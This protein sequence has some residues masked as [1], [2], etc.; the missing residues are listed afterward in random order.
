[1]TLHVIPATTEDLTAGEKT[2]LN[3]MKNIYGSVPRNVYLHV[4]PKIKN[5]EPDFVLVDP[6]RGVSVI[7]VKDW[8]MDYIINLN[9]REAKTRDGKT[10]QNPLF[11]TRTYYNF[12]KGIFESELKLIDDD[13]ELTF[14]LTA[15]VF[16]PNIKKDEIIG[17]EHEP[18]F[19]SCPAKSIMGDEFRG[20]TIKDLDIIFDRNGQCLKSDDVLAIR[21]SLFPEITI[22]KLSDDQGDIIKALDIEQENFARRISNGHYMVSG[23]PG[24]G[25]TVMLIARALHMIKQNPNWEVLILTYNKSLKDK[26]KYKINRVAEECKFMD[27]RVDRIRIKTYHSFALEVT[28]ATI[29]RGRQEWWDEELPL[30]TLEKAYPMYD[31]ILIDEYQ[32]FRA[33]WI[34]SC[35]KACKL[36]KDEEGKEYT[37]MF[38]SGD[39]LQSIYN[40]VECSWKDVGIN[41]VGR[42]KLLKRSYRTGKN[43][44]D[45][46]LKFLT[47]DP[48]LKKEVDKFYE[49]EGD[50]ENM[51]FD[52]D[53]GLIEGGYNEISKIVQQL[54]RVGGCEPSDIMILSKNKY[55]ISG[56]KES[57]PEDIIHLVN[58]EKE[59]KSGKLH[60]TTYHSSKGLETPICILSDTDSYSATSSHSNPIMDR[61]LLY[62]GMTRAHKSLYIH[63]KDF[64]R[65]SYGKDIKDIFES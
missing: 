59:P 16:F 4:Q 25:K 5:L 34:K 6:V 11:K 35:I 64:T 30:L 61:K 48:S 60:L 1:M 40:K 37:N 13:A 55:T 51:N 58:T 31:A 22:S 20:M 43:H 10:H 39:R 53:I 56:I 3:K 38:L 33:N 65:E 14:S 32:D 15:N 42:S 12:L 57:L 23:I 41:I 49:G 24:S 26:L 19:N 52:N 27:I 28:G 47:I 21:T 63:A 50:I 46:A 62:V 7:E 29:Q 44:I 45:L 54:I 17:Y 2:F 36:F 9:R 8:S 18:F